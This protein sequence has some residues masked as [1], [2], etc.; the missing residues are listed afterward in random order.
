MD[1]KIKVLPVEDYSQLKLEVEMLPREGTLDYLRE[2][3]PSSSTEK[4]TDS[5][6]RQILLFN[7]ILK[8]FPERLNLSKWKP[9]DLFNENYFPK[10]ELKEEQLCQQQSV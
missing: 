2:F 9:E 1:V 4:H 5:Q 3:L 10:P 7:L 8:H 6:L